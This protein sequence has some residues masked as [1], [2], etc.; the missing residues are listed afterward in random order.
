[1]KRIHTLKDKVLLLLLL[2]VAGMAEAQQ[3]EELQIGI[4]EDL[5][6]VCCIYTNTVFACGQNG[7]IL[8]TEDGGNSWQE[9]Y[10]QEGYDWYAIKF[11][12]PNTGFVLGISDEVGNNEKL[13]KTLDGGETWLDMGNP[14]NE[15]NYCSPS[16]CDL[17]IVDS[18]TLYVACDQLMKSTNGGYSFSQLDI[19]WM[20]SAQELFFEGN[21]GYIVW[22]E[23]GSFIG[24]HVAKTT[25]YG[26]SWEEILSFDD[27]EYGIEK[28][29]FHDKDHVALYILRS[30][31]K[32]D[33]QPLNGC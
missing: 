13:L 14:F 9:K 24:T 4:T 5:Y 17:F 2:V 22:G 30:K 18:D 29:V 31:P 28:A 15:Y 6:D 16:T 21:V 10:R 19:E 20:D 3:W 27:S 32:T 12:D 1:M 11:L 33:L 23:A 25:D 26:S 7:V 8:K